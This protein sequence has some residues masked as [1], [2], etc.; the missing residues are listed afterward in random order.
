MVNLQV[1]QDQEYRRRKDSKY[2]YKLL[3]T[4]NL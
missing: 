3:G 2:E 4:F 1:D